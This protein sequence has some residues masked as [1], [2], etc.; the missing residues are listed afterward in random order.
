MKLVS[1]SFY[2]RND[3]PNGLGLTLGPPS[4]TPEEVT[5][6]FSGETVREYFAASDAL[7]GEGIV[8]E[9]FDQLRVIADAAKRE[10][11]PMSQALIAALN[12]MWL[13]ERGH[14]VNDEFNGVMFIHA[15]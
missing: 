10:P 12:I 2:W 13:T 4:F 11:L 3:A 8:V 1:A 14:L 5:A 7:V 15:P 9:Y 6:M